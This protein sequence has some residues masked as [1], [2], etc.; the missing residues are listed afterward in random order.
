[1]NYVASAPVVGKWLA[2]KLGVWNRARMVNI[3]QGHD[4]YLSE[5][6]FIVNTWFHVF[7]LVS[8]AIVLRK[9]S[10]DAEVFDIGDEDC[11]LHMSC[12]TENSFLV[13]M[14]E[15]CIR[16][17]ISGLIVSCSVRWIHSVPVMNLYV[18]PL[19]D[20]EIAW[21]MDASEWYNRYTRCVSWQPA[22]RLPENKLWDYEIRLREGHANIPT[23]AVYTTT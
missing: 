14:Q 21:I 22:A 8:S 13:D 5:R 4:S 16:N 19:E 15:R 7:D 11:M 17:P 18:E 1:M 12:F 9:F 3:G 6:N 2:K 20:V 23:S 10:F